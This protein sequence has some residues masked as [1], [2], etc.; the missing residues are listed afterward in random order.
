MALTLLRFALRNV[1][2][3]PGRSLLMVLAMATFLFVLVFLKAVGDGY[4]AQRLDA[5]VGLSYGHVVVRPSDDRGAIA[6]AAAVAAVLRRDAGVRSV[7]ARIRAEGFAKSATDTAGVAVVGVDADTESSATRIATYV[8][9]GSFLPTTDA[10]DPAN[11]GR[12]AGSA[13][14]VPCVLGADLATKLRV[15]A[16]DRVALLV[17]GHDGALVADVHRVVGIFRTG[18][19]VFDATTVYVP[20]VALRTALAADGD[21][22]EVV[23]RVAD[24]LAADD[25]ARRVAAEPE[26]AA[27]SVQS[28]REAVPALLE[29]MEVM[30]VLE[31]IRGVTLFILVAVGI[32]DVVA[33]S[34]AER[35]RELAM[36]AAIGMRPGAIAA[37]VTLET[38][39][40]AAHAVAIGGG[41][42]VLVTALW[43]G[44]SGIDVASLG[45]NLPIG[46]E[47]M[48]VIHPVVTTGSL[49]TAAAWVAAVAL[50]VAVPPLA[51]ILR[52]DPAEALR[53]R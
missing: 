5:A 37:C 27:L 51:R 8:T 53:E 32:L 13:E 38:A 31:R 28:W 15:A 25:V 20:R 19:S 4:V 34:I 1:L 47:G 44:R 29:A 21:A 18:S 46:L 43:L 17:Q 39:I 48:R 9:D 23:A 22:T 50:A 40:V 33:M 35:R 24:P 6:D 52:M 2:R 36:L 14:L 10:S 30:R 26:L 3:H 49:A 45:A 41:A 7:I 42:S 11:A 16:G 12:A